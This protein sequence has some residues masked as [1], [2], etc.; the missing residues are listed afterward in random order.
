[1]NS[2]REKCNLEIEMEK[3]EQNQTC[4]EMKEIERNKRKGIKWKKKERTQ[5]IIENDD[6]TTNRKKR[7]KCKDKGDYYAV[8]VKGTIESKKKPPDK[9]QSIIIKG[10]WNRKVQER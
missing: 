4:E 8:K 7:I 6:P 3:G 10:S 1:M 5:E 2:R 9:I